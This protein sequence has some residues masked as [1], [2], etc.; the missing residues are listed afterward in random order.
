MPK[1]VKGSQLM[2]VDKVYVLAA[3]RHRYTKQTKPQWAKNESWAPHFIDDND[4]LEHSFFYVKK[5][6]YLDGRYN[7]C[8][9]YP[10]W[11]DNPEFRISKEA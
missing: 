5:D 6:G 10:T 11:P 1:R 9:S 2:D 8:E 7:R 4:W 3:Y